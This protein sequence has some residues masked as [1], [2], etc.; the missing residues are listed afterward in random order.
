[1]IG[2]LLVALVVHAFRF[3][4]GVMIHRN[5][6]A[7]RMAGGVIVVVVVVVVIV[8]VV[9]GY[10]AAGGSVVDAIVLMY[11]GVAAELEEATADTSGATIQRCGDCRWRRSTTEFGRVSKG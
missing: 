8:V 3:R 11:V 5:M 10:V 1:M 7:I 2:V 9:I 4:F 6:I